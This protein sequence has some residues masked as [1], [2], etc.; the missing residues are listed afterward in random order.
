LELQKCQTAALAELRAEVVA[1]RLDKHVVDAVAEADM[2][3][4]RGRPRIEALFA[5]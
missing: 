2:P 3:R 1:L 4:S 5:H